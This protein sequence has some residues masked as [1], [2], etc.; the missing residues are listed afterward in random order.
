MASLLAVSLGACTTTAA[1]SSRI[2][3]TRPG[4][5][6]LAADKAQNLMARQIGV[7]EALRQTAAPGA[8]VFAP[9]PTDAAGWLSEQE[10]F[11][12]TRWAARAVVISC[13]RLVGVT[14]GAIFWG[15]HPG[16]YTTIWRYDPGD[17]EGARG[18]WRWVL[19]HGEGLDEALPVQDRPQVAEASCDN[20][21]TLP[22]PTAQIGRSPDSSLTYEWDY[23]PE[24]GRK[25]SI[26][27][28]DGAK[29]QTVVED[30]VIAGQGE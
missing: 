5:A 26:E 15:D 23:L 1:D 12:E 4:M 27:I 6:V 24:R 20:L 28:W 3:Q 10:P 11:P 17:Q 21:P 25:L 7:L 18:Q 9:E 13:D 19:S 29:F 8:I 16:Y 30:E 14:T 2:S 22:G